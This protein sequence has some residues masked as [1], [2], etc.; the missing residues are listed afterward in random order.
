MKDRRALWHRSRMIVLQTEMILDID[1]GAINHD[2]P[3]HH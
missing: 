1:F 2:I 3:R